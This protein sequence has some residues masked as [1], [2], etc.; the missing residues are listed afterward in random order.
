MSTRDGHAFPQMC[1][2][3]VTVLVEPLKLHFSK[4]YMG[5]SLIDTESHAL[6]NGTTF[7]IALQQFPKI[8]S[9]FKHTLLHTRAAGAL[10]VSSAFN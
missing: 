6:I 9:I 3:A 2:I 10:R 4:R 1:P 5:F 8:R 7:K